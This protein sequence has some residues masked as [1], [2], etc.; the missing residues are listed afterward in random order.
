MARS[1]PHFM[2]VFSGFV[3][4]SVNII[5]HGDPLRFRAHNAVPFS[6]ASYYGDH[7]VLQQAQ[8]S[9]IWGY[10]PENGAKVT[11]NLIANDAGT[12]I[13]TL[14]VM[15]RPGP[16][17]GQFVWSA[18][19]DGPKA[20]SEAVFRVTA[21][22]GSDV[23]MLKDVL[24]GDVWICSGQSNMQF[25]MSM[26][27][28][29]KEEL[30]NLEQYNRIRVFTLKQV[31]S[32]T[33]LYDFASGSIEEL[34]SVPS[35]STIGG[36]DW[37]YMSAVCW[38]YGK[39][40]FNGL[41]R[42]VPIGLVASDWGGTPVEA[43]SSP[44][45]LAACNISQHANSNDKTSNVIQDGLFVDAPGTPS[46]LWN[47]MIHPFLNMSIYGAIWYQGEAN[48]G[49]PD[50]YNCTFPTMIEDWRMKFHEATNGATDPYFPFGFVQLAAWREGKNY[51]H[52]FPDIRWHQTAD[53]GYVPNYRM[54][55][56]FMAVA[57][58]LPDDTS[59]YSAI[60][61]RDKQD[62]AQRLALSGLNIAYGKPTTYHGPTITAYFID[63]GFYTLKIGLSMKIDKPHSNDGF[64][65]CCSKDNQTY[66][67]SGNAFWS[68]AP[69]I[70]YDQHSVTMSWKTCS[71]S[72]IVGLRYAWL[73]TPCA[74]KQCPV[75]SVINELPMAPFVTN[76]LIGGGRVGQDGPQ[77]LQGT[78]N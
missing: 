76:G 13:Q 3:L 64:E 21:K 11:V 29:S 63:I 32:A 7:M 62:V 30:M 52:G 15:S 35:T 26:V 18:A 1:G 46:H 4:L 37:K 68:P 70:G 53:V 9:A 65:V 71:G 78:L 49:A 24:F 61:P 60:H 75:Y 50:T 44:D 12:I 20:D 72:W 28:N 67:G 17:A 58:D 5:V 43:W 23:I 51:T 57:M 73:E 6:F 47:S 59:P 19:I 38:L 2:S 36:P 66:C 40:I 25:S 39:N 14:S 27:N 74:F 56:V 10:H 34:W 42:K 54:K 8:K 55:K 33:P 48:A 31:E 45:S 41:G 77:Y 22:S 16:V 69:L